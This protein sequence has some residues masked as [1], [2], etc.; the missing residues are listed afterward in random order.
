MKKK[1]SRSSISGAQSYKEIGDFWD[2]HDLADYW[3]ETQ[4]ADFDVHIESEVFYYA[5]MKTLSEQVQSLAQKQGLS[6]DTLVNLWVQEKLQ[7]E[8]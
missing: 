7:Q 5:L 3:D 1:G 8:A 2:S 4:E 6:A